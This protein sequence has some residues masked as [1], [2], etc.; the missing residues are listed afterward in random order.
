MAPVLNDGMVCGRCW[1]L[2]HVQKP[3]EE[4]VEDARQ[5][6]REQGWLTDEGFIWEEPERSS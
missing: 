1:G 6:A 3:S 2:Q 5:V 4:A